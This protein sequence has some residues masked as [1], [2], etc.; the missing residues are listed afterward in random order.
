MKSFWISGGAFVLKNGGLSLCPDCPCNNPEMEC[1]AWV[2]EAIRE[3]QI[4][5]GR[6]EWTGAD[7]T[8][9]ECRTE[10]GAIAKVFLQNPDY[11]E[12][13]LDAP[14]F[15]SSSYASNAADWCELWEFVRVLRTSGLV[16]NVS[17]NPGKPASGWWYRL[18]AHRF[19]ADY[20]P[21]HTTQVWS[22]PWS[23]PVDGARALWAPYSNPGY[24]PA[25]DTYLWSDQYGQ[26]ATAFEYGAIV[27]MVAPWCPVSR[28]GRFFV[29]FNHGTGNRTYD[30][31]GLHSMAEHQYALIWT[32]P[33]G[34]WDYWFDAATGKMWSIYSTAEWPA[35]PTAFLEHW[36]VDDT[37]PARHC[38]WA[39]TV[40]TLDWDFQYQ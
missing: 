32:S 17:G 18:A 36:P 22:Q 7:R 40:Y 16:I 8:F 35:Y 30:N 13:T 38:Q 25:A 6:T 23:V 10:V 39:T 4:P 27:R 1:E 33:T 12:G 21:N 34:I 11:A 5:A 26:H 37:V 15:W 31:H 28:T 20:P 9:A 2:R 24:V 29:E 14:A 3:R 19:I